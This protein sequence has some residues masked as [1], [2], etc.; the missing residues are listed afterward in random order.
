MS[1]IFETLRLTARRLQP[2]DLAS[3]FAVY[4]DA[5]AIRCFRRLC[6]TLAE[7]AARRETARR[8][9]SFELAF[10]LLCGE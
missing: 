1:F 7:L 6:P 3:L 2:D 9:V 10:C 8:D 4:G 5:A